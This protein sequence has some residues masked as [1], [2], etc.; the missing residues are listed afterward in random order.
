MV[1]GFTDKHPADIDRENGLV[2]VRHPGGTVVEV[3]RNR[4]A[5]MVAERGYE[6]VEKEDS[7]VDG[8]DG[9]TVEPTGEAGS[10]EHPAS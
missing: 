6:Y 1:L 7:D 9:G 4:A 3:G 10:S 8:H 5:L 2:E